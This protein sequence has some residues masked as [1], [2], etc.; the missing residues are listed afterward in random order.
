M[1]THGVVM[2]IMTTWLLQAQSWMCG[3]AH[4]S[5][6]TKTLKLRR[7]GAMRSYALCMT[8]YDSSRL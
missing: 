8:V 6:P 7:A 2:R 1:P 3:G 4:R 5:P